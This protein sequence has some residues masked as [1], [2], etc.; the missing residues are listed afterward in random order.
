MF[1]FSN[2]SS[3]WLKECIHY[4]KTLDTLQKAIFSCYLEKDHDNVHEKNIRTARKRL[5]QA[6][7]KLRSLP[8]KNA[9]ER[10]GKLENLYEIIFSLNTL[11]LRILDPSTF[12]I[13]KTEFK[14]IS[15][16]LSHILEHTTIFLDR[17]RNPRKKMSVQNLADQHAARMMDETGKNMGQLSRN[18]N[19]LDELYRATLQVVSQE[20]IFF[21][22]FLQ[23]LTAFRDV[24][25]S[26]F[27]DLLND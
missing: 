12:E 10:L 5:L 4:F 11:K 1:I 6:M 3:R 23:D 8:Y 18:I 27:M 16:S 20:P 13:C 15:D 14:K 9:N 22:F 21:L 19:D 2:K 25:E 24:F 17:Q 7:I 26:F